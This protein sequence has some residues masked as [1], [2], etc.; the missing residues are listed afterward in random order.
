MSDL[1]VGRDRATPPIAVEHLT[2]W[3]GTQRGVIDL[4]F[5]VH[6]G[7]IVGLLG[8]NAAGKTTTI[9]QLLGLVRPSSGTARIFGLDC[10]AES[11]RVKAK[12]GYLPGELR[13]PEGMTGGEFLAFLGAFRRGGNPHR[14]RALIERL[15]L[16]PTAR[17]KQLSKGNRQKLAIIQAL[18][19]D[20]PLL[21]LDEPS[22]GLDPLTQRVLL[23]LLQE[24]Q[25]RGK[26]IL[27]SSHMLPEV[28]R[29]AQRVAILR[30]GQLVAIEEVARLRAV[31]QRRVEVTLCHPVPPERFSALEGVRVRSVDP[32]GLHLEL[33][34]GAALQPLLRLLSDVPVEDVRITP[35]DV[36]SLFFHYYNDDHASSGPVVEATS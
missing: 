5:E 15:E 17:I 25:A 27:L 12:V 8:P 1:R 11:P 22:T 2:R 23:E 13:L 10:W 21:I 6:E 29:I 34:A 35:P 18:M 31:R 32:S 26:T 24:E 4:S 33:A 16:D 20:A 9:R 36:E 19:H 7:E 28:E 30:E 3:Y 14:R